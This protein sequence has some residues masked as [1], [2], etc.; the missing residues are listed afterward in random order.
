MAFADPQSLTIGGSAVSLARIV[1]N[2]TS[3][4]YIT[5]DGMHELEISQSG[6]N[7]LGSLVRLTVYKNV[8]LPGG[9][10]KRVPA[11]VGITFKRDSVGSFTN[12]ELVA[13]L[14]TVVTWLSASSYANGLKLAAREA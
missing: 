6:G 2:P 4:K 1:T 11:N 9:A 7:T 14:T 3:S 5:S 8:T 12:S 10:V 13:E